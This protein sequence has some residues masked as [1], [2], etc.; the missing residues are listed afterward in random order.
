VLLASLVREVLDGKDV[1]WKI[2]YAKGGLHPEQRRS[3]GFASYFYD[4]R[5]GN[6]SRARCREV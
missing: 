1:V 5:L 3:C 6:G 2:D 4:A